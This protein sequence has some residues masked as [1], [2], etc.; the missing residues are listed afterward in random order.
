MEII[1]GMV[2][3]LFLNI[4]LDNISLDLTFPFGLH[5]M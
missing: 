3:L 1:G 5:K 4:S 2:Y